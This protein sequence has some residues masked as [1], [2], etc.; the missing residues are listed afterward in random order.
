[1]SI[2]DAA[3]TLEFDSDTLRRWLHAN[4]PG[5]TGPMRLT[6]IG[7]GQSNPTFFVEFDDQSL[8]LRKQPSGVLLPSAHAVDRE[9]RI[10][11]VLAATDVP[12]PEV[13]AFCEDRS[14][15]GTPFYVM[16]KLEGRV[17][18]HTRLQEIATA[19]RRAYFLA[20]AET[21]A[22][23]HAVDW[24]T[25]GLSDYGKPGSFFERQVARWTRQWQA[26]KMRDNADIDRLIKWLP[27][28][29]P[30]DD[31]TTIAHG[32]FR[33]G[34]LM[35]H[36]SEPRV[37][38]LLDWEL[39][40]L[41]HPLADVGYVCMAWHMRPQEFDG[42]RGLDPAAEGLP[43]QDEFITHY[44]RHASRPLAVQPFHLA[45]AMFR[46]AV[47]LEGIGARARAGNAASADASQV[48]AQAIAF[49]RAAVKLID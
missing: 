35:W 29:V 34:N 44:L 22:R 32:D 40:T 30:A 4:L 39:S 23:L 15:V 13:L 45:F 48:A 36:P 2:A 14:I 38:A 33:M 25:A 5:L 46:F 37:I 20:M 24:R 31:I 47:I 1:M 16:R 8:V 9:A 26:S 3:D 12:V 19:E 21:L 7:G 10:M 41:G 17:L 18:P 49:S 6:R 27:R 43:T 28:H 11:K 42:I